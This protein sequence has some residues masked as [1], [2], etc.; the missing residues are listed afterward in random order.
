MGLYLVPG[1]VSLQ[2][3]GVWDLGLPC[4][5][6]WG[7]IVY[8]PSSS[9]VRFSGPASGS[10]LFLSA[11]LCLLMIFSLTPSCIRYLQ[12][13]GSVSF[14]FIKFCSQKSQNNSFSLRCKWLMWQS[15][16]WSGEGEIS[17]LRFPGIRKNGFLH[18]HLCGVLF[19]HILTQDP[20]LKSLSQG[21]S[22]RKSWL[23]LPL[24]LHLHSALPD[25]FVHRL[26]YLSSHKLVDFLKTAS[27][28]VSSASQVLEHCQAHIDC[29][30]KELG[31][32][33]RAV[34]TL[35]MVDYGLHGA[36]LN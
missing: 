28:S 18:V 26:V 24:S 21:S 8:N 25:Y 15:A 32:V 1:L 30:T 11:P 27:R 7:H 36:K 31:R 16:A 33:I 29:L 17:Y 14:F 3:F 5:T 13:S 19:L 23:F 20:V 6:L 34:L 4:C 12:F 10:L 35:I 22:P 9:T 2:V